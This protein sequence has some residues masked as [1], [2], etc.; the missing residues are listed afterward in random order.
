MIIIRRSG[1]LNSKASS[2]SLLMAQP[3]CLAAFSAMAMLPAP[4]DFTVYDLKT[5]PVEGFVQTFEECPFLRVHPAGASP[6]PVSAAAVQAI[7]MSSPALISCMLSHAAQS[8]P[9]LPK[10]ISGLCIP[11][12]KAG[13]GH[14]RKNPAVMPLLQLS[15]C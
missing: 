3:V 10:H 1:Q 2:P 6:V 12:R 11:V 8:G 14:I 13:S 15:V 4:P 5:L 9:V 7:A